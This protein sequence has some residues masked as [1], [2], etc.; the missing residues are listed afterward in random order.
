MNRK[1]DDFFVWKFGRMTFEVGRIFSDSTR[2]K[3][4]HSLSR[5]NLLQKNITTL[6]PYIYFLLSHSLRRKIIGFLLH[7]MGFFGF[8]TKTPQNESRW[9]CSSTGGCIWSIFVTTFPST[10]LKVQPGRTPAWRW[11][12][13]SQRFYQKVS[14]SPKRLQWYMFSVMY[15]CKTF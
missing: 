8:L 2:E 5:P 6:F 1:D 3:P 13:C 9:N 12:S 7:P 4:T 11:T 10:N 15:L 14:Q